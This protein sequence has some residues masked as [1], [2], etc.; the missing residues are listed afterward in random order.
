MPRSLS[1][2]L[3]SFDVFGTLISVRDGSYG[4]F[5]SILAD[6]P[7][8]NR[9]DVKEFFEYWE[10]RNIAH[11]WE[12]YRRYR[13]IA[14]LSLGEAFAHCGLHGDT[15]WIQRYFDAFG[16]FELY[17]EVTPTLRT[18]SRHYRLVLV[19]NIDDDLLA[20]TRLGRDF[21]LV[22]T[23]SGHAAISRTGPCSATSSSMPAWQRMRSSIPDSRNS[24]TWSAASRSAWRLPGS[25]DAALRCTH[26]Y[27]GPISYFPISH[28]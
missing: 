14:E 12:P 27:P 18:L 24:R 10:E 23:P 8:G 17:P 2:R 28:R 6:A 4:A 11:Y 25:I 15:R 22:C 26:P 3:L 7:G 20:A 21:D 13:D 1:P 5:R 19:S 16:E 9:V